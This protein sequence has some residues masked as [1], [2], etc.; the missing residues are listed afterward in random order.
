LQNTEKAVLKLDPALDPTNQEQPILPSSENKQEPSLLNFSH[1]EIN[2]LLQRKISDQKEKTESPEKNL[3]KSFA[4]EKIPPIKLGKKVFVNQL[5]ELTDILSQIG[6]CE[7][8][9]GKLLDGFE[10]KSPILLTQEEEEENPSQFD[11]LDFK[12][13]L[14]NEIEFLNKVFKRKLAGKQYLCL[15]G[16]SKFKQTINFMGLTHINFSRF[17]H[18]V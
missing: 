11:I 10:Y 14:P 7:R 12:I 8:S 3:N 9:Y 17:V 1:K 5:N 16:W 4:E 6:T 13:L 15:P 2:H 18:K